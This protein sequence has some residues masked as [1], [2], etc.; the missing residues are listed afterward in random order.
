MK[1]R[2]FALLL[3]LMV[4]LSAL[5]LSVM[6]SEIN[7]GEGE[8]DHGV[9]LESLDYDKDGEINY[10]ALGDSMTNGFGMGDY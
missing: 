6:A 8:H 3:A 10:V 9:D 5:P 4:T 2:I 1:K 7:S